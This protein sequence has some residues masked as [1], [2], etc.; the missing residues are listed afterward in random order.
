MSSS[1]H[2]I[3]I[4]ALRLKHKRQKSKEGIR[5]RDIKNEAYDDFK[6]KIDRFRTYKKE[7]PNSDKTKK[8]RGE[9]RE[10]HIYFLGV[11][12]EYETYINQDHNKCHPA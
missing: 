4:E 11:E 12:E 3:N 1:S 10:A 5:L 9:M 6:R 8:A 7:D 2:E